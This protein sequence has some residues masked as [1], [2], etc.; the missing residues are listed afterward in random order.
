MR[1]HSPRGFLVLGEWR[2]P[3]RSREAELDGGREAVRGT[4]NVCGGKALTARGAHRHVRHAQGCSCGDGP[5]TATATGT[6][7]TTVPAPNETCPDPAT[8][9][10]QLPRAARTERGKRTNRT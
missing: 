2:L 1:T 6:E 5:A 3:R 8:H 10:R 4:R 7:S 9:A